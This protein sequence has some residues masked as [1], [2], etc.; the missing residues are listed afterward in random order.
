M[1][2]HT[3]VFPPLSLTYPLWLQREPM[4]G[5][6]CWSVERDCLH[7]NLP[8]LS[9]PSPFF[10]VSLLS[11]LTLSPWLPLPIS[12]SAPSLFLMCWMAML[13][14][15]ER[16]CLPIAYCHFLHYDRPKGCFVLSLPPRNQHL[17]ENDMHCDTREEAA[18]RWA[19]GLSD[20]V[21]VVLCCYSLKGNKR[22]Q[23]FTNVK[24]H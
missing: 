9:Q 14:V 1:D 21:N 8:H 19:S 3:D 11:S 2:V 23:L 22:C 10:P 12:L 20:L 5:I 17:P 16:S 4:D 13:L 15:E 18:E 7:S 6:I 24:C